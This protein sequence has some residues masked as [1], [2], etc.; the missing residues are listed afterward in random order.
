MIQSIIDWLIK[1]SVEFTGAFL[2]ILYIVF[3]I[4]QHILTWLTGLLTSVLY[5]IVFFKAGL[6]A[7]M[8]LQFYYVGISFYG[9]YFWSKGKSQE[10]AAIVVNKV[11]PE[12]LIK[13]VLSTSIIWLIIFFILKKFTDSDVPVFDAITTSLS[14]VATWMLARKF[15]ENW[16][17]WIFVDSVSIV[18]YSYKKL[19]PTIILFSVYLIMAFFGY[20]QWKKD[21]K[22]EIETAA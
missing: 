17:I 22:P 16:L 3:S 14:I 12:L 21:L 15:I 7:A 5:I 8:S 11:K 13:L 20:I 18:L 6:Y 10:N 1:N 19:W 2:G 4:K 9:W